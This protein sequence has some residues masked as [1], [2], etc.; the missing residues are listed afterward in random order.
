MV[1]RAS[2]MVLSDY[3]SRWYCLIRE[4]ALM[5]RGSSITAPWKAAASLINFPA[6]EDTIRMASH[7]VVAIMRLAMEL[8]GRS[9]TLLLAEVSK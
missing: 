6:C 8:Y 2:I 3:N 1:R 4:S 7:R 5:S 9:T